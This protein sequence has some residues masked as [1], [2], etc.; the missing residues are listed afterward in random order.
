MATAELF[1][2]RHL[3]STDCCLVTHIGFATVVGDAVHLAAA[4]MVTCFVHNCQELRVTTVEELFDSL[5]GRGGGGGVG[6]LFW[7]GKYNENTTRGNQKYILE[8]L[9]TYIYISAV[10]FVV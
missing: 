9:N 3:K 7:R 6:M 1:Y 2:C 10:V 4:P 5:G 8:H